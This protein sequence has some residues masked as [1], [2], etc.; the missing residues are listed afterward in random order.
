[1]E[2]LA[3]FKWINN[4]SQVP[5]TLLFIGTAIVLT[6]KTGF[7]QIRA[8]P[9]FIRLI[10]YGVPSSKEQRTST[11]NIK[12]IDSFHALFAAMATTIGMGNIV[13]PSVAIVAGGPGALFWM[14]V[15]IFFGAVTKFTEV[16]FALRTRIKMPDG[17]VVGG[18]MQYL[19]KV[20]P[21]L[22]YWYIYVMIVAAACWSAA[23]ANT[24]AQVFARESIPEWTVG[25]ALALLVLVVLQGGAE[26]VGS[27]ASRLV[28][29]MF[30]L[31]VTFAITILLKD[32]PALGR[33]F[34]LIGRSIFE[35]A[36]A[37]GGF[38]GATIFA[39]MRSGIYKAI[40][41]TEAG[42]GTSS[43]PH[44][45]ADTKLATD[46]GV[47][48]LYSMLSDAFLCT[49]SGLLVL[50][51]GFW[52]TGEFKS[53]LVYEA[54]KLHSPGFGS[55]VLLMSIT[56]FVL[57]TVIGNSFNGLQNFSSLTGHK[58]VYWYIAFTMVTIFLG[59]LMHV[60]LIWEMMDTFV[61]LLAVPNLIGLLILTFKQPQALQE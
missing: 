9:R 1:M 49:L 30:V 56:L 35:P 52:M 29:L 28:P 59:S 24:L 12:T 50:V 48:A 44:A 13:G 11:H 17:Y 33:V 45:V 42:V 14:W 23:Q 3:L 40:Y 39:A 51:T 21:A 60:E 15:Y 47:L 46:Q 19:Q 32:I 53:T 22:G 31:Y 16:A 27:A 43:I 26:R 6:L 61:M 2:L 20:R 57:T 55:V 18:P 58:F 36:A 5:A 4:I 10:R 37:A 34:A 54:F 38:A 7:I 41:I 25:V 8:F